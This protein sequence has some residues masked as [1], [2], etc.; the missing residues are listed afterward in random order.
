MRKISDISLE[1]ILELTPAAPWNKEQPKVFVA[2]KKFNMKR[3]HVFDH[4]HHK[5][6]EKAM[7]HLVKFK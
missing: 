2:C 1:K 6:V 7:D 3:I 4:Y 5:T